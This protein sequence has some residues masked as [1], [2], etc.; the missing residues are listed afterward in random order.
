METG[1]EA[2]PLCTV[3]HYIVAAA[4]NGDFSSKVGLA[5]LKE[6]GRGG[7]P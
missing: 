3:Y 5:G 7:V 1:G 4:S 6:G 2:V